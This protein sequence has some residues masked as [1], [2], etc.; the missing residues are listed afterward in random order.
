[1]IRLVVFSE[2]LDM[3]KFSSSIRTPKR[4]TLSVA[5]PTP[6]SDSIAKQGADMLRSTKDKVGGPIMGDLGLPPKPNKG[7]ENTSKIIREVFNQED[8]EDA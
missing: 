2:G 8:K 3:S 5:N 4:V 1:M 6:R 7:R